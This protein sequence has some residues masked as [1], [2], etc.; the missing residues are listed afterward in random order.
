MSSSGGKVQ[1]IEVTA[2]P[3]EPGLAEAQR[4]YRDGRVREIVDLF[5]REA[6]IEA[7]SG[8]SPR[9]RIVLAM[10]RFDLGDVT[11]SIDGLE[12]IIRDLPESSRVRFDARLA[13]FLRSSDFQ[14][15][16]ELLPG[17]TELRQLA[18]RNGTAKILAGLHL[19]VARLEG[20]RGHF[21]DAY[22]HL[23]LS[24][25]LAEGE[26]DEALGCSLDLVEASL[27]FVGGNLPRSRKLAEA[28]RRKALA[29]SFSKY[30][31]G[32]TANLAIVALYEGQTDKSRR[33][34]EHVIP[35]TSDLTYVKLGAI[36]S[37]AQ[38]ELYEGNF[39]RAS[40]LLAQCALVTAGDRVPA[41]SWYDLAHQLTRCTY[42]ER[43]GEW[44]A[45][46]SIA[47]DTDPELVRRQYKAVRTTLLCAKARALARL[48]EHSRADAAL[49]LA[50]Q[51]CPR[52]AVDPLIVLEASR[53]A[54]ATLRGETS[55]GRTHFDR[56][57]AGCRAIG[58]RYHERWITA[59]RD[60]L[61]RHSVGTTVSAPRSIDTGSAGLVLTDVATIL[62]AGHSIDLMAHH[63][64]SLLQGTALGPRVD[65]DHEGGCEYQPDPTA[66]WDTQPDGTFS[67]HLRGSDRRIA[68][69]VTKVN[70]IDD[71][72]LLKSVADLVQVA[73]GRTADS[74]EDDDDQNLWPRAAIA[75]D[76]DAIFR[77]P[78]MVEL[79]KIATRLATTDLPVLITGETG[80][81]KEI[82]ARLIHEHS[83]HRR[84]PFVPF[85]CSAIARDLVESQLFGHR[86]GAFTGAHESS[87]GMIRAAEHGTLFLDEVGDLDLTRATETVAVSRV[88]RDPTSRRPAPTTGEGPPRGRHERQRRRRDRSGPFPARLVLPLG[89]HETR[90][91]A[92]ARTKGRNPGPRSPVPVALGAR[93]QPVWVETR[94]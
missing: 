42:H 26:L 78:R 92:P 34:F 2:L 14:S 18:A 91:P 30:V 51:T 85:N 13:L 72:A 7:A 81:G 36:D 94:G 11:S 43:L 31:L 24:R 56:A 22:R 60:E 69:R 53:A 16:E 65:V 6:G 28:C 66:S 5:P 45:I 1:S 25:R 90:A 3:D 35:L 55:A 86:R 9:L 64:A 46:V 17:L 38:L 73:V 74:E 49:G 58:H 27:E 63:T 54:C 33:Y 10:A 8:S 84:G 39:G 82:F 52:S 93:M 75:S 57:L 29:A 15:P 19:A 70:T 87:A 50:V 20:I 77:S 4:L 67:I 44:P 88:R 59:T 83:K 23:N 40:E 79:L 71:I 89:R 61:Q 62:G 21:G 12:A 80:T 37:L 47:E 41:R 76:E 48:G 32:S 68:I